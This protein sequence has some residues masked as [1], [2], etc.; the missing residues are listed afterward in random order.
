MADHLSKEGRSRNMAAIRSKNTKPEIAL[1]MALRQLGYSGYRLHR[2]D[3]PGRPDIAFVGRRVA[4][5]VDGAYWHGHPD[6]WHPESASEY[7]MTKITRN[8]E[9][10][11]AANEKLVSQG[12]QVIRLWD[13]EVLA[14]PLGCAEEVALRL[15]ALGP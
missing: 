14:D 13:F 10:D 5:F 6:H 1:R 8:Q 12:W 9:R 2:K 7:W 3:I 4:V 11:R 15:S